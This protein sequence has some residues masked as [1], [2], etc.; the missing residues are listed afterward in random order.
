MVIFILFQ[1]QIYSILI[2]A[3]HTNDIKK[4]VVEAKVHTITVVINIIIMFI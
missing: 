3:S 4:F 2:T 1:I